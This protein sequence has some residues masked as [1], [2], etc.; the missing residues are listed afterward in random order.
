MQKKNYISASQ[1]VMVLLIGMMVALFTLSSGYNFIDKQEVS[2]EKQ[3][4][5]TNDTQDETPVEQSSISSFNA[6][7]QGL[8]VNFPEF[9]GVIEKFIPTITD[10]PLQFVEYFEKS[11]TSFF[12][13]LFRRIISTNAP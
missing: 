10:R 12:K 3:E 7:S 8:Q 2:K 4:V 1:R 9:E 11:T 13:T 5:S 6:I